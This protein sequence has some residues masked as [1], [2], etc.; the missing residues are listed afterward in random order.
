MRRHYSFSVPGVE[1][2]RR[3]RARKQGRAVQVY[4][5]S[6]DRKREKDIREVFEA[7]CKAAYGRIVTA[8]AG[9]PVRVSIAAARDVRSDLRK[10]D[11][12]DQPDTST[13]DADNIAKSVLDALNP[14][15]DD[16]EGHPGAWADDAQVDE[17]HI[18][19]LRRERGAEPRTVVTIE[20][21]DQ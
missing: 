10:R 11:G 16:P 12:D 2:Q 18:Y 19:K 6:A 17:L 5:A 1:G 14:D 20:W 15:K 9:T 4:K 8:P 21:E 13:P 3:P 7:A